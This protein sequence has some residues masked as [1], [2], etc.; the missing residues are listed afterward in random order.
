M[1]EQPAGLPAGPWRKGNRDWDGLPLLD[2]TGRRWLWLSTGEFATEDAAADHVVASW[3]TARD[4][5]TALAFITEVHAAWRAW[6]DGDGHA[7]AD[8]GPAF[9]AVMAELMPE[10]ERSEE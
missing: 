1:S 7:L 2:A 3:Q 6:W 8:L 5:R 9:A 10:G 4:L